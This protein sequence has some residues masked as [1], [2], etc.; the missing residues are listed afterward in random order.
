MKSSCDI[1]LEDFEMLVVSLFMTY[2]PIAMTLILIK[3][4]TGK[5]QLEAFVTELQQM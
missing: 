5:L 2:H 3:A 1:V 4:A